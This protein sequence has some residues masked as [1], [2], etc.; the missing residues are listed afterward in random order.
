MANHP[1]PNKPV[2]VNIEMPGKLHHAVKKKAVDARK[3]LK[4]WLL[5]VVSEAAK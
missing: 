3:T 1:D 5:T 2:H 4:D